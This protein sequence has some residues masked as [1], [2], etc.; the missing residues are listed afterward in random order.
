MA[1]KLYEIEVYEEIRQRAIIEVEADSLGEARAEAIAAAPDVDP[2]LWTYEDCV[3]RW[4]G[5][6]YAVTESSEED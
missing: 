2:E 5:D 4:A 1:K 6:D 3:R